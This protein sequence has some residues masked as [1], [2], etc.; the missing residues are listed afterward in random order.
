VVVAKMY[1]TFLPLRAS[2]RQIHS[3]YFFDLYRY[4]NSWSVYR[5]V[6]M[7]IVFLCATQKLLTRRFY[8]VREWT[9][10]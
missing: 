7:Y 2:N 5:H 4:F 10:I 3:E 1:F 9:F 6:H 8:K